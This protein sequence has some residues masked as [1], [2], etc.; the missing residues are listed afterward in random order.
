MPGH[1]RS[2]CRLH[3]AWCRLHT[4]HVAAQL[5]SFRTS[6]RQERSNR[7]AAH[8]ARRNS[9]PSRTPLAVHLARAL[10]RAIPTT[11]TLRTLR[12]LLLSLTGLGLLSYAAWML[13]APAGLAAAGISV[14]VLE[15]LVSS[16]RGRGGSP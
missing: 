9:Q 8:A 16:D 12:T 3:H 4:D 10:A 5:T 1:T 6:F 13:A 15:Y 2:W 14:L 7:A 11:A